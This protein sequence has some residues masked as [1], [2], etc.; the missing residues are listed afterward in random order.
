MKRKSLLLKAEIDSS[1]MKGV[2]ATISTV[3]EY[4]HFHS[5]C[6]KHALL[7]KALFRTDA[8]IS[9]DRKFKACLK[10]ILDHTDEPFEN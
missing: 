6:I 5:I 4:I 2:D 7:M 3:D 8:V 10:Q 1:T 9:D